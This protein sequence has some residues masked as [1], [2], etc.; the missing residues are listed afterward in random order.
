MGKSNKRLQH[1]NQVKFVNTKQLSVRFWIKKQTFLTFWRFPVSKHCERQQQRTSL[2]SLEEFGS[3]VIWNR[4]W[5]TNPD[6]PSQ[7]AIPRSICAHARIWL[8]KVNRGITIARQRVSRGG[9]NLFPRYNTS[10]AKPSRATV[11]RACDQHPLAGV[12]LRRVGTSCMRKFIVPTLLF[13]SLFLLK[14]S[15][16]WEKTGTRTSVSAGKRKLEMSWR[17]RHWM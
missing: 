4:P 8:M 10:V 3:D 1:G 12:E 14:T 9:N 16:D 17:R 15:F 6:I 11:N 2:S 13:P 5:S 7:T